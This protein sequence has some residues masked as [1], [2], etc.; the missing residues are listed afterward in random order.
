[1]ETKELE[2]NV[3]SKTKKMAL[4]WALI[5]AHRIYAGKY[6]S[7][8]LFLILMLMCSIFP[9]D[10]ALKWF[11]YF[12]IGWFLYDVYRIYKGKFKDNKNLFITKWDDGEITLTKKKI[13]NGILIGYGGILIFINIL[14]KIEPYIKEKLANCK[15]FYVE[16]YG[17]YNDY[18]ELEKA[19]RKIKF[20][21]NCKKD[22]I[23][24]IN[25]KTYQI[26][27]GP[28]TI[29]YQLDFGKNVLKYYLKLQDEDKNEKEETLKYKVKPY[30][31]STNI[32]EIKDENGNTNEEEIK[33]TILGLKPLKLLINDQ[34]YELEQGSLK[35]IRYPLGLKN[36][37]I[38]LKFYVDNDLYEEKKI[39]IYRNFYQLET[40][41]EQIKDAAGK[42]KEKQV[43]FKIFSYK[44]GKILINNKEYP[45]NI[46]KT[47][48]IYFP[49]KYG[50]N[51]LNVSLVFEEEEPIN[52]N[53]TVYRKTPE[54]ILEEEKLACREDPKKFVEI[55]KFNWVVDAYMWIHYRILV[56]N[57][58]P[59]PI[60]DLQFEVS[61]YAASGTEIDS[62]VTKTAYIKIPPKQSRWINFNRA[63]TYILGT[64]EARSARI[65]VF[66]VEL[67][68]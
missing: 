57:N 22:G 31:F 58:C 32:E 62:N 35:T 47:N 29:E 37:K 55:Q 34:E 43:E 3:S 67:A 21:I 41:I 46:E 18:E 40:N 38:N 28:N 59:I 44:P 61:Y 60:K 20:H 23:L 24:T 14:T 5:G 30:E 13:L 19:D 10:P 50:D 9:L 6:I 2:N 49:L 17:G 36:N 12:V 63:D 1:M 7:G 26:K 65:K 51:N 11:F 56:K 53:Y 15:E 66:Y 54:E 27:T 4:L 39:E 42:T 25:D 68:E 52:F 48:K 16:P 33:F 8:I 64:D 45:I